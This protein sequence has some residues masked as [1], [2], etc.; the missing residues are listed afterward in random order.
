[1]FFAGG[2]F[3]ASGIA[4]FVFTTDPQTIGPGELSGAL[5]IQAQD[6]SGKEIKTEETVDLEFSSTSVTGEFL[7]ASSS[8]VSKV[9]NKGTANR[10]FYYRDSV[11]GFATLNIK[12]QGRDSGTSWTASQTIT[13]SGATASSNT[14]IPASAPAPIPLPP[15]SLQQSLPSS[16]INAD[17]GPDQTVTAGS[18]VD[19]KG[20]AV[21]LKKEPLE[22]ARFWWNFG[23]GETQEGRSTEHTF[24]IPGTYI[25]GLHVSSGEYASSDYATIHVLANQTRVARVLSGREGYIR[26]ANPLNAESDI[27]GWIIEDGSQK[28]FFVPSKTKLA[29]GGELSF[30]NA[31]TGLLQDETSYPLTIQYP[32]GTVALTYAPMPT[33]SRPAIGIPAASST[34]ATS[35]GSPSSRNALRAGEVS[36]IRKIGPDHAGKNK[37]NRAESNAKTNVTETRAQSATGAAGF[38]VSSRILFAGAV[39][40]SALGALGFLVLK[41]F[42]I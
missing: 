25:V 24:R 1:M 6:A 16:R 23:D 14:S 29:A 30:S 12:A 18:L 19:F 15:P 2:V 38:S 22:T 5:K 36:R 21:G 40:L 26:L 37:A 39:G 7:N 35:T 32:N 34:N 11:P 10:T 27:G 20:V 9:M 3:A 42:L 31:V 17:A 33:L 41:H 13:V 28:K 4:R 8:P